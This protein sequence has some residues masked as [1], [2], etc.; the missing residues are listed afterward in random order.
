MRRLTKTLTKKQNE[1]FEYIRRT[2]ASEKR[3]PTIREICAKFKMKSTKGAD[4]YLV[5]LE[6]KGY[7]KR[8]RNRSRGIKILMGG[9]PGD[10]SDNKEVRALPVVDDAN[11]KN[12]FELITN[13]KGTIYV[14]NRFLDTSGAFIAIAGDDGMSGDGIFK[15]DYVIVRPNTNIP[16]GKIVVTIVDKE[17]LVRVYSNVNRRIHL[18]VSA[19]N[20]RSYDR[21]VLSEGDD[22]WIVGE[23]IG[24]MRKTR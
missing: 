20:R 7:I 21:L 17:M 13:L 9:G 4:N 6:R 8:D 14:D 2:I 19:S 11:T 23:V 15:G 5:A 22:F 24:V 18:D 16:D 10:I 3:P 1:V 12:L